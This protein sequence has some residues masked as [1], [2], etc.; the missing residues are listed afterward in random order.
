MKRHLSCNVKGSR[1]R[2]RRSGRDGKLSDL[3]EVVDRGIAVG[4]H[5]GDS[6]PESELRLPAPLEALRRP[7]DGRRSDHVVNQ[8]D[9]ALGGDGIS[10]LKSAGD[11]PFRAREVGGGGGEEPDSGE[12]EDWRAFNR[13]RRA[14][15]RS[16]GPGKLELLELVR[17]RL[18]RPLQLGLFRR[19]SV[20]CGEKEE[21][22][23]E[24]GG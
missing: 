3:P 20:V 14:V 9:S 17:S 22:D 12:I 19:K 23:R 11:A 8:A 21:K 18:D 2:E 24:T 10:F 5:E 6:K 1:K 15:R 7:V 16:V 13:K 4:D